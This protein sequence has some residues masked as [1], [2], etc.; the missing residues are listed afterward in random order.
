MSWTKPL[1]LDEAVRAFA[2]MLP[3][4][5][6]M[7]M[8]WTSVISALGQGGFYFSSLPLHQKKGMRLVMGGLLWTVGL[9]FYLIGGNVVFNPWLAVVFTFF[10]GLNLVFLSGWK[11]LGPL[12]FSFISIYAAG[13][14]A[15][16]PE[17]VHQSFM[18]FVL[19]MG[20]AAVVSLLPI[21]KGT[22]APA[23]PAKEPAI[24]T[25]VEVGL[26]MGIG[27]AVAELISQVMGF[28][29]MGWA[30]SG[31]GNVIRFDVVTSKMRARLRMIGTVGGVMILM[32]SLR[33]TD[34]VL[35]LSAM[36]LVYAFINGLT[37]RTKLGQTIILYTATIMTL[38][39]LND[40]PGAKE[41][42]WDRIIFNLIGVMVGVFVALYPFPRLF[43]RIKSV[44]ATTGEDVQT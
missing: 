1:Q 9:G 41:L 15:S 39:A 30:T 11:M 16:S 10:V 19:S 3:M 14:N 38:Y 40:L 33:L 44:T 26:R 28:S 32:L 27:V 21:W 13:L 36:T 5:L 23:V 18:A 6:G 25:Q 35:V 12:A 22:P 4:V 43:S 2:C 34:S 29:K 42:S 24:G 7:F 31:A 37:K 8:G 20:W 17:K